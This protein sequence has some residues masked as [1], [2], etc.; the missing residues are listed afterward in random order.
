MEALLQG[1]DGGTT[2]DDIMGHGSRL[3]AVPPYHAVP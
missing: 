3:I 2:T 1:G